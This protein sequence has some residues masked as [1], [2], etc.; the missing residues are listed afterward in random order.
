MKFKNG[1]SIL[2]HCRVMT[3]GEICMRITSGGTPKRNNPDFYENG[4]CP[5]VKTQEL[6]DSW[7]E[8]TEEHITLSA[9][10]NSSTKLLPFETIL[11]A[12]YGATVGK[13]GILRRE[14]TCNQACCALIVDKSNADP[15][16]LS[17]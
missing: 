14:M 6:H 17:E 10:E 5:W 2:K 9:I 13:L 8:D 12:M 16:Y 15:I 1:K 3:L 7:I 11:M 4:S